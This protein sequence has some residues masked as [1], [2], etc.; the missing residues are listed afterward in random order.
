M[1][2][3]NIAIYLSDSEMINYLKDKEEINTDTRKFVKD[4]VKVD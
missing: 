1:S 4:K 3:I 2:T